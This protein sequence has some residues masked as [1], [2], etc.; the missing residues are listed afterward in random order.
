MGSSCQINN[1]RTGVKHIYIY[2]YI[3]RGNGYVKIRVAKL[4]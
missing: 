3:Y 2:I 4:D 1:D